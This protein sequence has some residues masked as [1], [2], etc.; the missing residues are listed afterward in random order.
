M[1]HPSTTV[2]AG[3]STEPVVRPRPRPARYGPS[4]SLALLGADVAALAGAVSIAQAWT[5]ES[6]LPLLLDPVGGPV[7]GF[8]LTLWLFLFERIGMYGRSFS[9]AA[10]DEL[11]A[12]FAASLIAMAP[13][14][15]LFFWVVAVRP[16]RAMLLTTLALAAIGLSLARYAV[17]VS[18]RELFPP[19]PRRIA[20]VGDPA[21]IAA[22]PADLS[23]ADRDEVTRFPVDDFDDGIAAAVASHDLTQLEWLRTALEH[24]CREIIVT[25]ALPAELMP[26]LLAA[27]EARGVKL[28]FAPM[29]LRPHACDF[30]VKRDGGLALVYAQS[31][32]IRSKGGRRVRRA[33]DLAFSIPALILLSPLLVALAI[34]TVV[35]S[36]R[37]IFFRQTRIGRDG[38]E[39][40]IIKFRTMRTD[41]E[42]RS[43]PVWAR[44][45]ENRTTRVGRIL[46]RTSFDELPQFFNVFRGDMSVVGPRPERP[47]YVEQ[48]RALLPRYNERHLTKP[49]ITGWSHIYMRRNVDTSAIGERLSYDLFYLEHWSIFMDLLIVCKTAA[50][51]LFHSA[52]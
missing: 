48:F 20:I 21:R 8:S 17:Y 14:A 3:I 33:F 10:R 23:L 30:V 35:D 51:F 1:T 13:A 18:R 5:H 46:R 22:V 27:T 25:E 9:T 47:F 32:A 7:V 36:G 16:E 37:P 26:P 52:A 41:A 15:V 39:F 6:L 42:Q 44:R 45:G 11:Y 50:E 31:L 24:G 38:R 2:G 43:G 29:R 28:A 40:K 49:G 12:S 34:A 4:W 19:A